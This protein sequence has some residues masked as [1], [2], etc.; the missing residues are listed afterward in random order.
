[1]MCPSCRQ[2]TLEPTWVSC[3][4]KDEEQMLFDVCTNCDYGINDHTEGVCSCEKLSS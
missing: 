3:L 4:D 1:M 2:D